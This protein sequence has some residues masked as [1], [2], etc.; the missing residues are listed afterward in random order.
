MTRPLVLLHG[1]SATAKAF[2]PLR[3]ALT[4]KGNALD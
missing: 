2:L 4:E 1:Y 3:A